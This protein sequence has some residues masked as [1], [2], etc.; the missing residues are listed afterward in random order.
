MIQAALFLVLLQPP[1]SILC[2]APD[3]N[4]GW[5]GRIAK[6][7]HKRTDGPLATIEAARDRLRKLPPGTPAMVEVEPGT[8]RITAPIVF[9]PQDSGSG[10]GDRAYYGSRGAVISGMRRIA[11]WRQLPN[12]WVVAKIPA[13]W[14]F[15][16]L[17]VNGE[18]RY[19]PRMPKQGY[20]TI[21]GTVAPTDAAKGRG[22]DRFQFNA[23][24]IRSDWA[25]RDDVEILAFH[26]W[27]MSR[28]RIG[29]VDDASHV[30][31][32]KA[33]TGYDA[34][35]DD[36]PKGNRYLVENVKEALSEPGEWYLDKPTH[37]LTYVPKPGESIANI[38][39][40]AP[41]A[42][43]LIEFR[44]DLATK[45]WVRHIVVAGFG[46]QGTNWNL[47]PNGRNFPQAEADLSG[48]VRFT[49]ARDCKLQGCSLAHFGAYAVDI[50]AASKNITVAVN[51]MTDLGG[52]GVKVGEQGWQKDPDLITEHCSIDSNVIQGG[53]RL[54]PAAVG[55]W[56]GQNPYI[57][58]TNNFIRDLYYTGVSVG[59]S[60]GYAPDGAHDN[61]IVDNRISMIGQGVLSDMGGIYTLGIQPGTVLRG[62]RIHDVQSFSYGGWGIYQDEGS[63][64]ILIENNC[65]FRMKSADVHQHYG[66]E[67]LYRN[68]VFAFG[69][70]A[71][72]MRTRAE[73][74]LSFTMSGNIIYFGDD[75]LL[76]S[77]WSGDNYKL[78][79]NLYWRIGGK[80]FD[81]AGMT[82]DQWHAKG[83]DVHSVIADP[84]FVDP[85]KGDFRLKPGSPALKMGFK[86]FP[87]LDPA[88]DGGAYRSLPRA[89][90]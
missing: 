79:G 48:A 54:H 44:G 39:V 25:N 27:S 24:E 36:L 71:Q 90:P 66:Q 77:N 28:N 18:R 29:S 16:Q 42:E 64:H 67:N 33:P 15:S 31:T 47:P 51:T 19:R 22:F 63:S 41:V 17:F 65:V 81:F 5:S 80:P 46:L 75:P 55:V 52:G 34:S 84:M 70:E 9:T 76:A 86:P 50:G 7:N 14:D 40:E 87:A 30:V 26:Y 82:P 72:I 11:G 85:A 78:D 56:I 4:D 13:E 61:L 69:G 6:P 68:N 21:T 43:S 49:G 2:V 38:D 58:V 88:F 89:F 37:T 1:K 35:W 8:Y 3:G 32:F 45:T 74:H 59:W 12:G 62:N 73:D 57:K 10:I 60:W 83:Q 53:G 23:G 20:Y